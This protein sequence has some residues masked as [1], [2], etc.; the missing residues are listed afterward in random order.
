M[1]TK[2]TILMAVMAVFVLMISTSVSASYYNNY[3]GNN[4]PNSASSNFF[5]QDS[6]NKFTN[7][8]FNFGLSSFNNVQNSN[9]NDFLTQGFFNNNYAD[10]N[11]NGI[12]SLGQSGSFNKKPCATR[13]ITAV[14]GF[15]DYKVKEKVCDGVSGTFNYNN[16]YQNAIDNNQGYN[17]ANFGLSGAKGSE[18]NSLSQSNNQASF[19]KYF[20]FGQQTSFGKGTYLVFN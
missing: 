20:S 19:N 12:I 6:A 10:F 4:Y 8:G 9:S 3:H 1:M 13:V 11:Q 2:K 15:K 17:Q 18:S 7:E 16:V 14:G 5:I